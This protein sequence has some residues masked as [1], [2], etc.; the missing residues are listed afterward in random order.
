MSTVTRLNAYLSG[1]DPSPDKAIYSLAA[2]HIYDE[3]CRIADIGSL[4]GRR[5]AVDSLP[6]TIRER[7]KEE[8]K[9]I[10]RIRRG[11]TER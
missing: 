11:Q 6:E 8:L 5:A 10:W 4:D 1:A 2:K 3:A 9:R 7:V